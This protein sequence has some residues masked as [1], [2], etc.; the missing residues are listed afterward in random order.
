MKRKET[1]HNRL[2][3]AWRFADHLLPNALIAAGIMASVLLTWNQPLRTTFLLALSLVIQATHH[4]APGDRAAMLAAALLGTPAEIV[5]VHLGEWTYVA[6][7]LVFGVPVWISL[8]WANL[9]ALFRRL[10]RSW[11]ALLDL[12]P[13]SV[14]PARTAIAGILILP[15]V[16]L[17]GAALILM[18]KPPVVRGLYAL[19]I[20]ITAL[21]WHREMDRLIFLTGAVLGAFG[22]FVAVQL[23]Y[24][25]YYNPLF[26]AYGVDITLP[27]DW[28]LSAV[29][30]HRIASL[31]HPRTTE[32]ES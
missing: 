9:F 19:M 24:W 25:S 22:E 3:N 1:N 28:G 13:G 32:R 4:P 31:W 26:K 23:G 16:S 10:A 29:I 12:G 7:D 15:I 20:L 17:W 11:T 5:E 18:D 8:I 30:I 21:F 27:L 6:P 2:I 14:G